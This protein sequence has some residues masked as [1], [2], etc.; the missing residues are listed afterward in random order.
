MGFEVI[1]RRG[2]IPG[3]GFLVGFRFRKFKTTYIV[4]DV[5]GEK[6]GKDLDSMVPGGF[7]GHVI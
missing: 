2:Y 3:Y 4:N 1:Y 5:I 6:G 7:K